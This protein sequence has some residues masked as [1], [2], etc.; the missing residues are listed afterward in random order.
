MFSL[1]WRR[2]RRAAASV[3]QIAKVCDE[4]QFLQERSD[5]KRPEYVISNVK[6]RV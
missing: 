5:G 4:S 2:G 1:V 3:S 6:S